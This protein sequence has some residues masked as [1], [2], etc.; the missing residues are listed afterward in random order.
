MTRTPWPTVA[1][2][3]AAPVA[4]NIA[5][6]GLG[7]SFGYP[8]VLDLP[9]AE[10]LARFTAAQ[11]AVSIWF[12]VLAVAAGALAPLA[13]L[14]GRRTPAPR[15]R[16][17]VAVGVTAAL[18]QVIGLLRWPVLVPGL[19][20]RAAADGP[21]SPAVDTFDLLGTVLGT[22]L[23]ETVGYTLTAAWT[24]LVAAALRDR[25]PRWFTTL[26]YLCA[27]AI[28]AGVLVPLGV[29]A[30]SP[31]NFAGYI[32]WSIWLI[33]FAA[34]LTR[35]PSGQRSGAH[36]TN[37]GDTQR[38]PLSDRGEDCPTGCDEPADY[39]HRA[40]GIRTRARWSR[41]SPSGCAPARGD[42]SSA[43]GDRRP[44]VDGTQRS[45]QRQP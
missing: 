31:I 13:V 18:V 38:R 45:R 20:D 32:G 8:D 6:T 19:A 23:G 33:A 25:M 27:A 42:A 35:T 22:I 1:L 21:G 43:R 15:M 30:A 11:P 40:P 34:L 16:A 29:D 10:A 5:F 17:A 28:G 3:I 44:A 12:T 4:M 24:I 2:L 41:S 39:R 7:A 37:P 36:S 26:G 14:V 9:P